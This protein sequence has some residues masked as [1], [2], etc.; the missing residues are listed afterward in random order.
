M[1]YGDN[2]LDDDAGILKH[3]QDID[4]VVSDS[5]KYGF[6]LET[7]ESQF[8]QLDK[9]GLVNYNR[10]TNE[11]KVKLNASDNPEVV[12]LL[13]NHNPRSTVLLRVL[14]DPEIIAYGN[15]NSFD[16]RFFVSSCAG[17]G[18]H[19]D[20]MLTLTQF[21]DLLKSIHKR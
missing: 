8:N 1:K 6:L 20:C 19:S 18:L 3:L 14:D 16:L 2:A 15:N 10:C 7:M 12:L 13:T 4:A 9:L 21:T 5:D 17:Y 11:T